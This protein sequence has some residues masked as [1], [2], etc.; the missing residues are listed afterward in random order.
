MFCQKCG[1]EIP[2]GKKFCADCGTPVAAKENN[3]KN[4]KIILK[5]IITMIY[6][7]LKL[8]KNFK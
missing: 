5:I 4:N 7:L 6:L 8:L 3:G 1:A 2:E